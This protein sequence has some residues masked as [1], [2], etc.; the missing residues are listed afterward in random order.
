MQKSYLT[1]T[2]SGSAT[3]C[4]CVINKKSMVA[5]NLGDS[6]FL[7]IRDLEDSELYEPYIV[8]KSKPMQHN[9]NTPFQLTKMPDI[10]KIQ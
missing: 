2:S 3:C 7:L 9:F 1:V 6:G 4:I 10:T 5:A 8:L